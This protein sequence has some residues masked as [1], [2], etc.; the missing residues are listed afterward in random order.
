MYLFFCIFLWPKTNFTSLAVASVIIDRIFSYKH[1]VYSY[2]QQPS[3]HGITRIFA[4]PKNNKIKII[5]MTH[6]RR[7]YHLRSQSNN[8][9]ARTASYTHH[10]HS[11]LVYLEVGVGVVW[12]R[13]LWSSFNHENHN[14]ISFPLHF[15]WKLFISLAHGCLIIHIYLS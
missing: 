8:Q 15:I 11:T 12:Q 13:F 3:F 7:D 2:M 1:I 14:S 10:V 9:N 6:I 4:S 5:I